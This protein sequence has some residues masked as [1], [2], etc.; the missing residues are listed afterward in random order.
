M[1]CLLRQLY[2]GSSDNDL[3]LY[4]YLT[5]FDILNN[6]IETWDCEVSPI[7]LLVALFVIVR[8][9]NYLTQTEAP[10]TSSLCTV[11]VIYTTLFHFFRNPVSMENG[12]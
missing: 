4:V 1:Q 2:L 5:R 9:A 8:I 7:L 6:F 10:A 11:D 3:L 12:Y